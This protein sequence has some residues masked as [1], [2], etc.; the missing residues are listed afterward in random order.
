MA[1]APPTSSSP[2]TLTEGVQQP[3]PLKGIVSSNDDP[4][5]CARCSIFIQDLNDVIVSFCCGRGI[6][7]SCDDAE[8]ELKH[9]PQCNSP[10]GKTP[11]E[12]IACL[13]KHSKKGHP[14]AQERLAV[15]YCAGNG[16]R[17]SR[18]EALHW[19]LQAAKR[20]HPIAM[21]IIGS[22]FLLGV[23]ECPVDLHQA[24]K[25][26]EA[27]LKASKPSFT[28]CYES[29]Q[30]GLVEVAERHCAAKA[31]EKARTILLPLAEEG[32]GNAQKALGDAIIR[33][34]RQNALSSA[35]FWYASAA[36]AL[37]GGP[38]KCRVHVD[39]LL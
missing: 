6:C 19:N 2:T 1:A 5:R 37:E 8:D 7:E 34:A 31:F 27:G 4:T 30:T 22:C 23:F 18:S 36:F 11:K 15:L 24:Q 33:A 32:V 35:L 39:G 38:W 12:K 28:A 14:W 13:K 26:F 29:C 10:F 25:Y 17:E 20:G 9:C 16:V 3:H 21:E